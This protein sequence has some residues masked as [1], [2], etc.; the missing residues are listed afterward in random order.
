MTAPT[1]L[2]RILSWHEDPWLQARAATTLGRFTVWCAAAGLLP[3]KWRLPVLPFLALAQF[4]PGRRIELLAIGSLW[5][6]FDRLP[7]SV[8]ALGPVRALPGMLLVL[9]VPATVFLAARSFGR[10]P[11]WVRRY[12]DVILHVLLWGG[13]GLA[14]ALPA[15]VAL[16][17]GSLPWVLVRSLQRLLPF[18]VWRCGYVMLSGKR[19]TAQKSRF[20]DHLFYCLPLWGGTLTPF[21]KGYDYLRQ[22][23][24]EA[25]DQIAAA[26]LSGVKLLALSWIWTGAGMLLAAA[27]FGK[28][29]GPLSALLGER[30]LAVPRLAEAIAAGGALPLTLTTRWAAVVCELLF[31]TAE[32]AASGHVIIGILRLFGFRVF[33]NTYKPLLA[34]SLVDFWNR[35][36][37]YFKELLVEFFFFPVYV[38]SF[39][40]HPRLRIFAATMAAAAFGNLYFHLLRDFGQMLLV[41]REVAA[42]RVGSRLFYSV[43]LGVGIFVSMLRERRRRGGAAR[44]R[45]VWP[46]LGRIRAIAGVWLF[47]SLIRVWS[48]EPVSLGFWQRSRFFL[49]LWGLT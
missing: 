25:R 8:R 20:R 3:D 7:L 9:A 38:S 1:G 31:R 42:S 5:V 30:H 34:A 14:Y 6:L 18:L 49:S 44:P 19:G 13:A 10:L 28:P 29:A 16:R 4:F 41:P 17:P 36:Y 43:L 39:K 45:G 40:R 11:P 46:A 23:R 32:L 37:Y 47:Y 24:A 21:G 26:Q 27:V 22:N 48:V 15:A 33:R 12:P 35:F 2:R